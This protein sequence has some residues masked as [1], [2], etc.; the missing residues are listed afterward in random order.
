MKS[1]LRDNY[2]GAV[3]TLE[4]RIQSE[5]TSARSKIMAAGDKETLTADDLENLATDLLR[6]RDRVMVL[7]HEKQVLEGVVMQLGFQK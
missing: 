5:V 3:E 4:I 7:G 1:N 2:Q 6:H